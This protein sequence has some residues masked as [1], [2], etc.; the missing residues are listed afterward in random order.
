MQPTQ[1]NKWIPVYAIYSL[2]LFDSGGAAA[3]EFQ[4]LYALNLKETLPWPT[5]QTSICIPAAPFNAELIS[6]KRR[7]NGKHSSTYIHPIISEF[8]FNKINIYLYLLCELLS[9]NSA[10]SRGDGHMAGVCVCVWEKSTY[11]VYRH[12]GD[13]SPVQLCACAC[14]SFWQRTAGFG[15]LPCCPSRVLEPRWRGQMD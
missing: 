9:I 12:G 13:V 6:F 14:L 2:H 7:Q 8:E 1:L 4:T 15:H 10:E 5:P 11:C 3:A